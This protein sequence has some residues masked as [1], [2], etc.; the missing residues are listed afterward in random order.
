MRRTI[1]PA[2]LQALLREDGGLHGLLEEILRSPDTTLAM[3]GDRAEVISAGAKTAVITRDPDGWQVT[4]MAAETETEADPEDLLRQTYETANNQGAGS[5]GTDYYITEVEEA[6]VEKRE[7]YGTE[8]EDY[9]RFFDLAGARWPRDKRTDMNGGIMTFVTLAE[10]PQD[11]KIQGRVRDLTKLAEKPWKLN[12]VCSDVKMLFHQKCQLGLVTIPE[13]DNYRHFRKEDYWLQVDPD[14][15]EFLI[16]VKEGDPA[17]LTEVV[18]EDFPLMVRVGRQ[19][20][21]PELLAENLR[22]LQ[23]IRREQNN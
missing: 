14:K 3:R 18:P 8:A 5:D 16:L 6:D 20:D 19:D 23:D 22:R 7:K 17:D 4:R 9:W 2:M 12:H 21:G 15:T 13:T 11:P 1:E 10:N